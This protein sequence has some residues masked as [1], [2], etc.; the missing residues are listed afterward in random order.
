MSIKRVMDAV[1]AFRMLDLIRKPFRSWEAYKLKLI[2]DQG[3]LI[4]RPETVREKS[5]YTSFHSTVRSLKQS[6]QRYGGQSVGNL[7]AAKIGYENL[8]EKYGKPEYTL[9]MLYEAMVAGDSGGNVENIASGEKSGS[10]VDK[11][12]ATMGTKKKRKVE[13]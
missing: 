12:P 3:N 13:K 6:L 10:I 8:T 7:M 2:D 11:G 4:K 1:Y 5:A 9:D